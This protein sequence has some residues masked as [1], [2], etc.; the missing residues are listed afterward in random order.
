MS[1]QLLINCKSPK[2]SG[3]QDAP[4][5]QMILKFNMLLS[6]AD[7][8]SP[9]YSQAPIDL[10]ELLSKTINQYPVHFVIKITKSLSR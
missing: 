1:E 9:V 6:S 2:K 10:K 8:Y 7:R 3:R 5:Q 4:F